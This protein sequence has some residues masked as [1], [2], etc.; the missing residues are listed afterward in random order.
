MVNCVKGINIEAISCAVPARKLSIQEY[1]PALL[2]EK[3][4]KRM[5]KG[6]GFKF[7]SYF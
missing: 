1:A 5:A 4:A 6:T 7:S 2:T 3:S